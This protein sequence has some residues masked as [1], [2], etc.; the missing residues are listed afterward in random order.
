M[1]TIGLVHAAPRGVHPWDFRLTRVGI[2]PHETNR[3]SQWVVGVL[4]SQSGG[5]V[6][7]PVE[8]AE[9]RLGAVLPVDSPR[10]LHLH[11]DKV[12]VTALRWFGG[13]LRVP[14]ADSWQICSAWSQSHPSP[15]FNV[16]VRGKQPEIF[17]NRLGVYKH[18]SLLSVTEVIK[19]SVP[20]QSVEPKMVRKRHPWMAVRT[21]VD[22]PRSWQVGGQ[23]Y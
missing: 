14:L 1:L 21:V 13:W 12:R 4:Q 11:G 3:E 2:H 22:L 8:E 23:I 6:L 19:H 20:F 16:P 18:I 17:L 7:S 15:K 9:M 10:I 5:G